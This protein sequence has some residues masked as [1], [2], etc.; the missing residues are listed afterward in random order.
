MK[1]LKLDVDQVKVDSFDADGNGSVRAHSYT[2]PS[3]VECDT[4]RQDSCYSCPAPPWCPPM[5]ISWDG[6]C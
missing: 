1:K 5:P 4:G 2:Y 3:G 6:N